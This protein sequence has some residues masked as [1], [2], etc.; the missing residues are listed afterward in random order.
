MKMLVSVE[1]KVSLQL[2]TSGCVEFIF[3]IVHNIPV[4]C[5][6]TMVNGC[7]RCVVGSDSHCCPARVPL[8]QM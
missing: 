1:E 2:L 8:V 7:G 4:M 6:V 5:Q 3:K